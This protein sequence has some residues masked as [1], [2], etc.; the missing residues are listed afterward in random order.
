MDDVD[1]M[2][3]EFVEVG[4]G[5]GELCGVGGGVEVA[6]VL[7]LAVGEGGGDVADEWGAA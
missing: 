5:V 6:G 2:G 3:G 1:D 4:E 7:G